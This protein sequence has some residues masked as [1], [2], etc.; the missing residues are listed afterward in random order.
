MGKYITLLLLCFLLLTMAEA[1]VLKDVS[2]TLP[3][4]EAV[5]FMVSKGIMDANNG[6]FKGPKIVTKFDLAVYLYNFYKYMVYSSESG[7]ASKK[8]PKSS[9]VEERVKIISDQRVDMI[10]RLLKYDSRSND[11]ERI[12][13][14]ERKVTALGDLVSSLSKRSMEAPDISSINDKLSTIFNKIEAIE[15]E[16]KLIKDR[17]QKLEDAAGQQ[18]KEM[19]S[20]SMMLESQEKAISENGESINEMK[21]SYLDL[22]E[23]YDT[24]IKDTDVLK[25]ELN[26]LKNMM[27]SYAVKITNHENKLLNIQYQLSK[28]SDKVEATIASTAVKSETHA[29]T[30]LALEKCL[31]EVKELKNNVENMKKT[32]L[33]LKAKL[34]ELNDAVNEVKGAEEKIDYLM[35]SV[36]VLNANQKKFDESSR[37]L[38]ILSSLSVVLSITAIVTAVVVGLFF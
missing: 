12:E 36:G 35:K 14:L 13:K 25:S 9:T 10:L 3:E 27:A 30:P 20:M 17:L 6:Y 29:S 38:L 37:N 26:T 1:V 21:S 5:K 11:F 16:R 8:T 31:S 2:P 28:L 19:E 7:V 4:Y 32:E 23:K 15:K 24:L 33:D 22:K 34:K 18:K